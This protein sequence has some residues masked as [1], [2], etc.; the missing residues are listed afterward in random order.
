MQ[1]DAV[2]AS[3]LESGAA[4]VAATPAAERPADHV[5]TSTEAQ[6]AA[7]SVHVPGLPAAALH[8]QGIL[9]QQQQQQQVLAQSVV[10]LQEAAAS[11]QHDWMRAGVQV[12]QCENAVKA[13]YS[14]VIKCGP[15][16]KVF[17]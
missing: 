10:A 16:K 8:Q 4:V 13:D 6:G 5:G 2:A 3:K 7:G 1:I 11:L 9:Q 14:G 15:F 17:A 12:S